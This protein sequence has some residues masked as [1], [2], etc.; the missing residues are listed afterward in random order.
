M[1]LSGR[2]LSRLKSLPFVV[3][4]NRD[5]FVVTTT[6][7]DKLMAASGSN[8]SNNAIKPLGYMT[9]V[10]IANHGI[11]GGYLLVNERA[12]PI[13]FHCTAPV[14]ASRTQEILYGKTFRS[15]LICDQIGQALLSQASQQPSL[16]LTDEMDVLELRKQIDMPVALFVSDD[17]DARLLQDYW[18]FELSGCSITTAQ[19]YEEDRAMVRDLIRQIDPTWDL[20]EPLERIRAAIQEAQ[21][22][23]A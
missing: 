19:D 22:A 23:A 1:R 4:C 3:R 14:L 2:Y 21:R 17:H 7:N 16:L 5:S 20:I 12:R 13:E 8:S 9:F 15:A 10:E 18:S 6:V 11:V